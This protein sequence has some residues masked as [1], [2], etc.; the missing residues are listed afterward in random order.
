MV[1]CLEL[2][3]NDLHMHMVQLMPLPP[4]VYCFIKVQNGLPFW[5][6]AYPGCPGKMP[7]NGCSSS[8]VTCHITCHAYATSMTSICLSVCNIGGL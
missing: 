5:F 4:I 7:L 2:G 3:T 6:P 1:I 8:N